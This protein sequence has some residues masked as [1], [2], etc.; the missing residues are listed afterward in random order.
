M[1]QDLSDKRKEYSKNYIDFN[2]VP[3]NPISLFS[4]WFNEV[5]QSKLIDEPYAMNISTLEKNGFP[6]NRIVLLREF[7]EEGFVFYTNY[8]SQKGQAIAHNP[9]VCLSFFWDKLERQVIITGEAEKISAEK[10]DDY[11]NKR[12]FE[13]RLGAL[14]SNQSEAIDFDYDLDENVKIL[15]EKFTETEIKRPENWGGYL[16]R[17]YQIE[18][19]QGRPSRLHDRIRYS[20]KGSNW[21]KERL[22]P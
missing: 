22:S 16:I 13:S 8:N 4:S 3:S 2:S 9:K 21:N 19:W 20:K 14:V 17:P 5:S 15:Q 12:P 6:K 18:F 1:E 7:N 10:S 11:F